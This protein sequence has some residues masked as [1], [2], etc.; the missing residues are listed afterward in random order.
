MADPTPSAPVTFRIVD[1]RHD[2]RYLPGGQRVG[3]WTIT[4]ETPS[5]VQSQTVIPDENYNAPNVAAAIAHHTYTIEQV[6]ALTEGRPPAQEGG[7]G[8]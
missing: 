5:G 6:H 3:E 2:W 1:Q 7:S 8:A 4:F